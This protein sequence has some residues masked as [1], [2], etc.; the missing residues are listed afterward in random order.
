MRESHTTDRN[1]VSNMSNT[2]LTVIEWKKKKNSLNENS[3]ENCQKAIVQNSIFFSKIELTKNINSSKPLQI[4]N[5]KATKEDLV[6]LLK[7]VTESH[8]IE[9]EKILQ[10]NPQLV[11][12]TGT[13]EDLSGRK[14]DNITVF[15]YAAWALDIEMCYVI[16]SYLDNVSAADQLKSLE[17]NPEKYSQYGAHYDIT[18]SIKKKDEYLKNCTKWEDDKCCD[19]WQKEVG[20]AQKQY[21]A[22]L[23]YAMCEEGEN[24]VWVNKNLKDMKITRQY[25][26]E[27]LKWWFTNEYNGGALGEKFGI[28]RGIVGESY[29][30]S[31]I[32][33][34][35]NLTYIDYGFE[36]DR[37]VEQVVKETCCEALEYIKIH[38]NLKTEFMRK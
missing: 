2:N 1:N 4:S 16:L 11:Y 15:Q 20:G 14:F 8:L 13:V 9:V 26:K 38:L 6:L 36:Q 19:Y 33:F 31:G 35:G 10:K 37:I 23:V 22:W 34:D 7:W 5:E 12:I 3:K 27:H 18:P 30:F 28:I 29:V 24:V 17:T 21:P 25:D 32:A